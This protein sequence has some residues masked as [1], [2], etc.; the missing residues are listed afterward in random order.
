MR[1]DFREER[2]WKTALAFHLVTAV[3][4]WHAA[5]TLA[6]RVGKKIV[7]LWKP[8]RKDE[9]K[10]IDEQMNVDNRS[11]QTPM[12]DYNSSDNDNDNEEDGP[13]PVPLEAKDVTDTLDTSTAVQDALDIAEAAASAFGIT[14]QFRSISQGGQ[15]EPKIEESDISAFHKNDGTE[16]SMNVDSSTPQDSQPGSSE[17]EKASKT[18]EYSRPSGLK[19]SSTNPLFPS[20]SNLQPEESSSHSKHAS[21]QNVYAPM[22]ERIASSDDHKLFLDL[23]DYD[24]LVKDLAALSEEN[25]HEMPPPPHDLSA[26]FPDLQPFG[27]LNI[28]DTGVTE[29]KKKSDRKSDKDDPNKRTEDTTY[30]NLVPLGKFNHC[31]PTLLGPMNPAK[32]WKQGK[33]ANQE[34]S[35]SN[36]ENDSS[37]SVDSLCGQFVQFVNSGLN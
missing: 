36:S 25:I 10:E 28:P 27:L 17:E 4:E 26:I 24:Y 7:V 32:R 35:A 33:W 31:K 6:D 5:G 29:V 37:L 20:T 14:N 19:V 21:K 22:R 15:V 9:E 12:V 30:A 1:T 11:M 16:E 13:G 3:L 18:E 23:D 34:D 8:P 2:K